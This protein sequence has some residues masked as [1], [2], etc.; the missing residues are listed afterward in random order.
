M[1]RKG[2]TTFVASVAVSFLLAGSLG[3][4]AKTQ[5]AQSKQE[6][7][8]ELETLKKKLSDVEELLDE[9]DE[10]VGSNERHTATDRVAWSVDLRTEINSLHYQDA[11]VLPEFAQVM[12]GLWAFDELAVPFT[13]YGLATD[14]NNDN[15][16]DYTFNG[17]F[18]QAYSP[19]LQG[20]MPDMFMGG[21]FSG[22]Y[23]P[24]GA[25]GFG[26]PANSFVSAADA[27][28]MMVANG[29][30]P[31]NR[32]DVASFMGMFSAAAPDAMP[33]IANSATGAGAP[34]FGREFNSDARAMYQ[35]MFNSIAPDK[36][37]IDNDVITTTRIWLDMRSD[38]TPHLT[39]GG[40]LSANKVWGDST[41]VGWFNGSFDS[42]TMDGNVHQKGSDS[43]I[44]LERGFV[45][46]RNDLGDVHWHFSLGRRPALGGAPWEVST[47]GQLGASPLVHAINWQF[48]GASLGFDISKLTSLEGMNFKICYGQ[49]FESGAGSGNSYA[50]DYSSDV[51][52]VNFLGYI[53]RL[54]DDGKTKVSHM[55]ARAM[56]VTDGFTGLTAIPFSITGID[57]NN[58]GVYDSFFLDANTGG[59]ISRFQ[60]TSNIGDIDLITMVAQTKVKGVDLF[61]DLAA[62]LTH[63]NGRSRNPMMQFMGADAMLNSN[64]GDEAHDGY[65]VWAGIKVPIAATEGALGFEYNWGS[66][67]WF[68]FNESEDTL[69]ASKLAV[70]GDVYELYY[71]QPV[72]GTKFLIS[73]GGQYYDYEYTGSGNPLGAPRK[74]R[75]PLPSMPSC[76][77]PTNSGPRIST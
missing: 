55:Y 76:R 40:R 64:G 18:A 32:A 34:L 30:N 7:E 33:V 48:D 59:Y 45:T 21:F 16:P 47:N 14:V 74:S 24:S 8:T 15:R 36:Q 46:Y 51:K 9:L 13:D 62:N 69:G 38:P 65:S 58:D 28:A 60:P 67:Y 63:P 11:L 29:M 26:I 73:L 4:P 41:G 53:F 44:R 42:I 50:M 35:G 22:F 56:N 2:S 49:G 54:Y 19:V 3:L 10:R 57:P 20:M 71:H 39:F 12:M 43:A 5:A 75:R 72:I 52:D 25:A 70:R 17:T 31:T 61:V 23:L 37:D 27:G 68:G 6:L 66:K 1:V 77:W